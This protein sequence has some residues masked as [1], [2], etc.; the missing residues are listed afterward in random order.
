MDPQTAAALW[1]QYIEPQVAKG[2]K[3]CS[4]AM[5]SRPNGK[6]WMS[7]FMAACK[8]CTVCAHIVSLHAAIDSFMYQV[9]YQCVHWYDIGFDNLKTYLTD[10][11]N[12]LGLP[13]LLT[14]F[15]DQNFNGGAQASQG[16]IFQFMGQAL[17]FFDETDWILAACPFGTSLSSLLPTTL[18]FVFVRCHA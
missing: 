5:S 17:K 18:T 15:A 13:I 2:Y 1:K 14:E 16:E 3:T 11:H 9:D 12:Q 10:Y 7:D 4:P 6:N 8:D